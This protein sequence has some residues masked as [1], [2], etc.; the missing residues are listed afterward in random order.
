ML[1]NYDCGV[2]HNLAAFSIRCSLEY[3]SE[4]NFGTRWLLKFHFWIEP[5]R[6]RQVALDSNQ[7]LSLSFE[8]HF[9]VLSNAVDVLESSD[10]ML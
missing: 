1:S 4:N 2:N 6:V 3:A 5:V 10:I 8:H 9:S 7:K